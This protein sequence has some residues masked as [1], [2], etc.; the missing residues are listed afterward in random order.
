MDMYLIKKEGQI[1]ELT[2]EI[3]DRIH[4]LSSRTFE[5]YVR[6][7]SYIA[8]GDKLDEAEKIISEIR[9]LLEE[10]STLDGCSK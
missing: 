4:Q 9:Q 1:K 2:K 8:L 3:Q 10:L 6:G 5:H 7:D